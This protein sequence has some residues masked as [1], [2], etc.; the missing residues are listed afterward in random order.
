MSRTHSILTLP[1]MT[2]AGTDPGL[3]RCPCP[4]SLPLLLRSIGARLIEFRMSEKS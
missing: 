4:L 3:C 1:L 2:A